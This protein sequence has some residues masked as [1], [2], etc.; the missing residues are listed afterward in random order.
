MMTTNTT[1]RRTVVRTVTTAAPSQGF[2]G[3]GHTA[4]FAIDPSEF[5]QQDPFIMM[6]DDRL[7]LPEG[8]TVGGEHPHAGFEIAT[9]LLEGSVHDQDEGVLRAGDLQWM[10]AGSGVIHGE[11]VTSSP[12]TRLLQLWYALPEE[13]RWKAPSF[14]TITRDQAE[15][16][17][18]QGFEVRRYSGASGTA[19]DSEPTAS[20]LII[21]EAKLDAGVRLEQQLPGA[22]NAFLYVLDGEVRVGEGSGVLL[23]A[24]QI[25]WL[26]RPGVNGPSALTL[27]AGDSGARSVL[28]AGEPQHVSIAMHGPFVGGSRADLMRMSRDWMD[29]RFQRMSALVRAAKAKSAG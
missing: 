10:V 24:G 28:Y 27:V 26:D 21:A 1:L 20:R 15:V 8:T 17:R 23:R 9:F 29:G 7:D 3:P 12:R 22:F 4:V 6:A 19:R 18:G 25:G 5:A 13:E 16:R 11:H 2:A 14:G